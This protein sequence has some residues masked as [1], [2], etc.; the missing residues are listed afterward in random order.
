MQMINGDAVWT[1]EVFRDYA[2]VRRTQRIT[3]VRSEGAQQLSLLRTTTRIK[4]DRRKK[5]EQGSS[6]LS[7]VSTL[8]HD[9]DTAILPVRLSVCPSVH[10]L[11]S[12]IVRKRL[13][14]ML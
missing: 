14:T 11:C 13:K 8:T 5:S 1:V 9:N 12:G 3:Y 2:T 10:P 7:R 4:T 6:F